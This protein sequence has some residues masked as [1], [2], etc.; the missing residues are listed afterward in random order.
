MASEGDR[1]IALLRYANYQKVGR[2]LHVSRSAV[3]DWAKGK[4]VTPYRLHQLEQLLRPDLQIEESAPPD[5]AERLLVGVMALETKGQVSE[6]ELDRAEALA[7]AWLATAEQRGR[8]RR[9]GGGVGGV[10][11]A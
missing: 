10:S 11:N 2:A 7:A 5:W 8:R 4:S 6:A 9:G 1:A 3:A